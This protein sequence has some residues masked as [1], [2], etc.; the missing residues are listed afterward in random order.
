MQAGDTIRAMPPH[1]HEVSNKNESNADLVMLVRTAAFE[2]RAR[3][4]Q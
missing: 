2:S 3:A 4:P 1:R